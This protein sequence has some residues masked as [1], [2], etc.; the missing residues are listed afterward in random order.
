M[1][2]G[3]GKFGKWLAHRW[4]YT[5]LR[6][7]IDD[8]LTVDHVC[9]NTRCVNVEH[10]EL[11][12]LSENTRRQIERMRRNGTLVPTICKKRG[13]PLAGDN[14]FVGKSGLR[15]CKECRKIVGREW[16]RRYRAAKK[17]AA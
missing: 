3:Y 8:E 4:I 7:V 9:A 5:L 14:L 1:P 15:Q 16:M 13:H 6:H 10:M 2:R 11:V 12:S 17:G